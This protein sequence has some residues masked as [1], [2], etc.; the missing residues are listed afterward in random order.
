VR[1]TSRVEALS[2]MHITPL[3]D[4]VVEATEE[5]IV[6]CLLAADTMVGRDGVTAHGLD[7]ARLLEVMSQYRRGPLAR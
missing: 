4:A 7:G 2:N 1:L 6:N 3:F 5:A